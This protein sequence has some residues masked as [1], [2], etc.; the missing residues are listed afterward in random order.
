MEWAAGMGLQ[1]IRLLKFLVSFC[2]SILPCSLYLL[3][4]WYAGV[5]NVGNDRQDVDG[6]DNREGV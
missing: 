2:Y 6:D 5:E 4:R 1:V 3:V